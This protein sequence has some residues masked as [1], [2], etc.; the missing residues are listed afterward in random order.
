MNEEEEL[1]D[2]SLILH[3]IIG[4]ALCG[5][6][7]LLNKL[8][9]AYAS[10]KISAAGDFCKTIYVENITISTERRLINK[11]IVSFRAKLRKTGNEFEITNDVYRVI[12]REYR[13]RVDS[14]HPY[15]HKKL[16]NSCNDF[17]DMKFISREIE[18]LFRD[19]RLC[20]NLAF[21]TYTIQ[22]KKINSAREEF[23]NE[24]LTREVLFTSTEGSI[25]SEPLY[26]INKKKEIVSVASFLE[27]SNVAIKTL[28]LEK[29]PIKL[30]QRICPDNYTKSY[31]FSLECE[32]SSENFNASYLRDY[33]ELSWRLDAFLPKNTSIKS[34]LPKS[35]KPIHILN[36]YEYALTTKPALMYLKFD[37]V[38]ATLI[39]H[40]DHFILYTKQFSSSFIH[41]LPKKV[42][43]I[44]KDYKF[45]VEANLYSTKKQRGGLPKPNPLVIIDI[46]TSTLTAF[47]RMTI[48]QHLR[49]KL[50]IYLYDYYIF[51]QGEILPNSQYG[52]NKKPEK[53]RAIKL[54]DNHIYEVILSRR[55]KRRVRRI[56]RARPDKSKP[57]S[58]KL[59]NTVFEL[60]SQ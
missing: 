25:F 40:N 56:I 51:F 39:F 23:L 12:E 24:T 26:V 50:S 42:I 17:S 1:Y 55:D 30:Y 43:Y 11:V 33:F 2:F 45:L 22:Y 27:C 16:N 15:L 41:T 8:L 13:K 28:Y 4:N 32:T 20:I 34:I 59:I 36:Q 7:T 52:I 21:D 48:L 60:L 19:Y 9:A 57:N 6:P 38:P 47:E 35:S 53:Q 5:R 54:C 3:E 58:S 46:Q 31:P 44:L 10:N 49:S 14:S 18:I 37:G 29:G